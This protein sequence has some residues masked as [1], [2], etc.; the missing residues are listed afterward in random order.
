[1]SRGRVRVD[2]DT[3]LRYII[4]WA[5]ATLRPGLTV[6]EVYGDSLDGSAD[7]EIS[8]EDDSEIEVSHDACRAFDALGKAFSMEVHNDNRRISVHVRAPTAREMPMLRKMVH[9]QL[10]ELTKLVM[11][12]WMSVLLLFAGLYI[13][14]KSAHKF[15][16]HCGD[17]DSPMRTAVDFLFHYVYAL[18]IYAGDWV[19]D[20]APWPL[21]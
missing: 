21:Q 5:G 4:G 16:E 3:A 10:R 11:P 18:T 13:C 17:V 15:E 1:M 6:S 9:S 19:R 20:R 2:K 12:T 14:W 7:F 8:A